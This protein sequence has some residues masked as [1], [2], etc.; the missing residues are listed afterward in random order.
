M[1]LRS[2]Q[3]LQALF[4]L[5]LWFTPLAPAHRR[6]ICKAQD[7]D[8]DLTAYESDEHPV[9]LPKYD[10]SDDKSENSHDNSF[11]ISPLPPIYVI[12]LDRATDRW[13]NVISAMNASGIRSYEYTRLP[14]VDGRMLS[15]EQL[16]EHATKLAVF[17]QPKG[18]LGCYLSHQ[19]FWKLVVQQRL[20]RA[21][22]LEDDVK[23]VEGFRDKLA[24]NLQAAGPSEDFDVLFLGAIGNALLTLNTVSAFC[25]PHVLFVLVLAMATGRVHPEG[26]DDFGKLNYLL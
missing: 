26:R 23:L 3:L 6:T 10:H 8:Q 19:R 15:T 25:V 1:E 5:M 13:N 16:L 18:V 17:L 24:V 9:A 7:I 4:T 21:I 12:N 11:A 14:A 2:S 22:V 20:E